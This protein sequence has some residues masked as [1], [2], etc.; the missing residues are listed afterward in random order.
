MGKIQKL[1]SLNLFQFAYYN[2][3]RKNVVRDRGC[4]ILPGRGSKIELHKTAKI[5]LR[6]NLHLNIN[7]YPGSDAECYLRLRKGAEMT[8]DGRVSLAYN[9]TIEAHEGA[10]LSIGETFLNSGAVIICAYKMTIGHGCLLARHAMVFDSDH[11]RMFDDDGKITNS[12]Q[13][14]IIGDNVWL[15]MK[16]TVLKGSIIQSGSIVGANSLAKGE[17][18]PHSLIA[19]ESAREVSKIN[20]PAEGFDNEEVEDGPARAR[21][22]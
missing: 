9:A 1:L 15:C 5:I 2:F 16:S 14:V 18:G 20:W 8:V 3:F 21:L 17:F 10:S 11:H 7:Q 6:A 19:S 22:L 4:Y 13:E 12:P